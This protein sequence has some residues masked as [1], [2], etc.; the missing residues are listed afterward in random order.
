VA[1]TNSPFGFRPIS[2]IGG[3]P[4]SV[5]EYAKAAADAT[6]AIF[7]NDIVY[8][9]ATSVA[10]PTGVGVPIPGCTSAQYGTPG[11]TLWLGPS[12]NYGVIATL[13]VQTVADEPDL[14]TMA[15][16]DATTSITVASHIG[17]NANL[18]ATNGLTTTKQSQMTINHTGIA[19]TST[20]DFRLIAVSA[21]QPNAEGVYAIVE[22]VCNKHQF[23]QQ[24]AGV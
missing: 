24:T 1:N 15:Q 13:T 3:I 11:T 8:K 23:G 20:L 22:C 4:W 18:L 2:R 7:M 19:T 9:A 14:I 5:S 21:E 10:N 17:K 6:Y 16:V 12:L